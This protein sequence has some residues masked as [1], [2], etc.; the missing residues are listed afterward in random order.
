MATFKFV[1]VDLTEAKPLADL[2]GAATDLKSARDLAKYLADQ[3]ASGTAD[4]EIVD[5]FSTS[6]LVRYARPFMTGVRAKLGEDTLKNLTPEQTQLHDKFIAWRNKH[7]AHSVNPFE[8]NHVVAYYTKETVAETGIDN[9][10]VQQDRLVGLCMQDLED[11]QKLADTVLA[12]VNARIDAEKSRVL[13][14]VRAKPVAE[15][16]AVGIKPRD[17]AGIDAV[18]KVRKEV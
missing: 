11:M 15:V 2:S 3:I 6:I 8:D 16:I 18:N 17:T 10:S 1:D 14:I 5:A 4:L 13:E 9:I 12:A 7:M